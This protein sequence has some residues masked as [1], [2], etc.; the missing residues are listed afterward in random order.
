MLLRQCHAQAIDQQGDV[1]LAFAQRRQFQRHHV[2]PVIQVFAKT[3]GAD[4]LCQVAPGGGDHAHIDGD[5]PRLAHRLAFAGLQETQQLGLHARRHLADLV[6][7]QRALVR[8]RHVTHVVGNRAGKGALA[9][10]VEQ[11]LGE[12]FRQRS[13][14]DRD[15]VVVRALALA[16]Q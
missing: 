11:G 14:V 9:M 8:R 6:E 13:A 16:V 1:A 2:Q 7:K 15:K 10:P 3:P 5:R 12:R 4:F